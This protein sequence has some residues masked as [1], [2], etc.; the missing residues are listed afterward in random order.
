[1]GVPSDRFEGRDVYIDYDF[2]D[3]MFRFEHRSKRF[4]RRFYGDAHETQVPHAS[5]LL[6]DAILM[7]EETDW[8]TYDAGKP[9]A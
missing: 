6:N 7:G 5:D 4:Y 8:K 2:E 1:M 9:K 3:V